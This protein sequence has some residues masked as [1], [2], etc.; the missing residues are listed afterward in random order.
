MFSKYN[1]KPQCQN[2][3]GSPTKIWHADQVSIREGI[4]VDIHSYNNLRFNKNVFK[5]CMRE[6][7]ASSTIGEGIIYLYA[8]ERN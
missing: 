4:E 2:Y 5:K 8:E 6:K 3:H 7:I 1:I